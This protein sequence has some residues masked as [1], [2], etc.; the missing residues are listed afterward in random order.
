MG[1]ACKFV[2]MENSIDTHLRAKIQTYLSD[3]LW[4]VHQSQV[5]H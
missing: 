3:N 5:F 1:I 4:L 2:K